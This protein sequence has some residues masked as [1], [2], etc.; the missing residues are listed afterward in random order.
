MN[1]A[2]EKLDKRI[3][4]L[5]KRR[6]L[7]DAKL[8]EKRRKQETRKKIIVGGLVL[9]YGKDGQ[10]PEEDLKALLDRTLSHEKDREL[11]NL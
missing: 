7:L 10:W 2:I 6:Q 11:F 3:D 4:Q 5:K 8:R 9:A 1:K